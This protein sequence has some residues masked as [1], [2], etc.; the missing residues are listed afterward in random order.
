MRSISSGRR[1]AGP[2]AP[3]PI[4]ST[5]GSML[6]T[7]QHLAVEIEERDVDVQFTRDAAALLRRQLAQSTIEL[8]KT[9]RFDQLLHMPGCVRVRDCSRQ[10]VRCL[11]FAGHLT[12]E[13]AIDLVSSHVRL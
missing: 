2:S 11:Q 3:T 5:Y 8:R 13:C 12:Q 4:T 10:F 9:R 7:P 6:G 1:P